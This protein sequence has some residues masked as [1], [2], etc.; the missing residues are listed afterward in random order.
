VERARAEGISLV[1]PDGVLSASI[2]HV[3]ETTLEAERAEH[4]G[5]EKPDPA[6]RDRG[7][8]RSIVGTS[9]A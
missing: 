2:R 9:A 4:L 7:N 6:G 5:H 3:L 8:S 1:E